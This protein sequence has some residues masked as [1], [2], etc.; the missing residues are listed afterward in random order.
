VKNL[1]IKGVAIACLLCTSFAAFAG[2]PAPKGWLMVRDGVANRD[3]NYANEDSDSNGALHGVSVLCAAS[4]DTPANITAL[5]AT[6]GTRN[7]GANHGVATTTT[8]IN[9]GG[10]VVKDPQP[11]NPNHCLINGLKTS[12]IKGIWH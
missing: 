5:I 11:N 9:L 8:A 7:W 10:N 3:A 6:D 4:S 12:Q 2:G 1:T